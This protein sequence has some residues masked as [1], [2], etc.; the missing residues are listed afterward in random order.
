M[1]EPETQMTVALL[2]ASVSAS[3]LGLLVIL[4]MARRLSR[5]ERLLTRHDGRQDESVPAPSMAETSAG[6]AFEAFLN[7]APERRGLT[8]GEQFAAYRQWRHEN[9]MNWTA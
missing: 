5:I 7:E 2:I 1:T 9:G 6:G 8:K 3:S 4:W